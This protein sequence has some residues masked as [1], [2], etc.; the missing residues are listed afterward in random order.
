MHFF[1]TFKISDDYHM[2]LK[3]S[4]DKIDNNSKHLMYCSTMM[5]VEKIMNHAFI[6][7]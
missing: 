1:L 5:D 7:Y 3:H 2:P 4:K 6:L